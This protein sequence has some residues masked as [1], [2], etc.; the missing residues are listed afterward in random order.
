[1]SPPRSVT[2]LRLLRLGTRFYLT[3]VIVL[4]YALLII[5][6]LVFAHSTGEEGAAYPTGDDVRHLVR[7]VFAVLCGVCVVLPHWRRYEQWAYGIYG[8]AL[9]GLVAVLLFGPEVRSTRRWLDLGIMRFQVS[10]V[11]KVALII[12]LARYLKATREKQSV[13]TSLWTLVL[14]LLPG[15]LIAKEPDLGTSLLLPPILFTLLFA[16]RGRPAHI[17]IIFLAGVAFA[18]VFYEVGLADYQKRRIDAFMSPDAAELDPD[19]VLQLKRSQGAIGTG[20]LT[21]KGL[22]EGDRGLPVR[23]ADFIFAVIAEETG[24]LGAGFLLLLYAALAY[25][26][27][28]IAAGT[29]DLFGRLV[30]VAMGVSV[31]IQTL[32][33]V[34]MT[35]GLLP[36]TGLNLPLVSQG[37]SSLLATSLGLGLVVNI[38]LRPPHSLALRSRLLRERAT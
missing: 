12:A 7:T 5:Y 1:M 31:S 26:C 33:N 36:I 9:L 15:L 29:Y 4:V 14:T 30:C 11:A 20:G 19:A 13:K 16:A 38:G 10:E 2:L 37:G 34:A 25:F 17:L 21:G 6:G 8:L 3:C 18:A 24:F 35:L 22:G 28:E 27:M 23:K 32:T